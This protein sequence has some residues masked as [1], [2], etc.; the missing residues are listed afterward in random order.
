MTKYCGIGQLSCTRSSVRDLNVKAYRLLVPEHLSD[1]E[2]LPGNRRHRPAIKGDLRRS[3]EP[4]PLDV[5][6]HISAICSI[7]EQNATLT[8]AD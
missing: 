8:A 2:E 4:I 5:N 7:L 6:L 1:V 3:I